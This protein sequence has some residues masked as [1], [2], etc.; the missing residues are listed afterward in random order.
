MTMSN[1]GSRI[2]Q[3]RSG[4]G[5]SQAKIGE[6]C[7]VTRAAVTQWESNETIP[8]TPKLIPLSDILDVAIDWL[9][10]GKSESPDLPPV[11]NPPGGGY[12]PVPESSGRLAAGHGAEDQDA[13]TRDVHYFS[14]NTIRYELNA[15]P[16]DCE[17][18]RVEGDSMVPTLR[19]HDRVMVDLSKKAPSPGGVFALFDGLSVIVKRLEYIHGSDPPT[20]RI[21]SDNDRHPNYER[22]LEEAHIIGRV[23]WRA[24]RL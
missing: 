11:V 23:I 21:I 17:V 15:R 10:K 2:A 3:A 18:I 5:F 24:R 20:V 6:A 9:L 16:E 13:E 19:P 22:T 14:E 12:V 1:L 4:R 8:E 7:G